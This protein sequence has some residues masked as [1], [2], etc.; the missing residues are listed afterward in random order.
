MSHKLLL[1]GCPTPTALMWS[2]ARI[3][4]HVPVTETLIIIFLLFGRRTTE[5]QFRVRHTLQQLCD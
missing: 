1:L 5:T 4:S 3:E 2:H